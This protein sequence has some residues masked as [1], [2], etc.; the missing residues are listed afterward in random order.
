MKIAG[1]RAT[2]RPSRDSLLGTRFDPSHELKSYERNLT[3]DGEFVRKLKARDPQA[4][5]A[6]VERF[7][8]PL[9]RYFLA[10]HGDDQL[11]AE[12]SADCFGDLVVSLPKMTGESDQLRAFVFAVAR[13]VLRRSWRSQS[14]LLHCKAL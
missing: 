1:K 10:S 6:L 13:N 12:Q 8:A 7:E 3:T 4:Y 14:A 11:A 5:R 9:Y 2:F